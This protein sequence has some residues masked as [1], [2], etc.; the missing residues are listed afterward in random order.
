MHAFG[1]S[2][3]SRGATRNKSFGGEADHLALARVPL[4]LRYREEISRRLGTR[5]RYGM[6]HGRIVEDAGR[7][8]AGGTAEG[9]TEGKSSKSSNGMGARGKVVS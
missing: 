1:S 9:K 8:E 3:A 4:R 5:Y 6:R 7:E 2:A